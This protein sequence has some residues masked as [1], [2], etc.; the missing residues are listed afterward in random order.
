M[1]VENSMVVLPRLRFGAV[2]K[3]LLALGIE[4]FHVFTMRTPVLSGQTAWRGLRLK[5]K[6]RGDRRLEMFSTIEVVI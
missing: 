5:I 6:E 1:E 2:F 3:G 4:N